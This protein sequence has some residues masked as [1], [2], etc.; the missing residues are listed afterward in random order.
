[1]TTNWGDADFDDEPQTNTVKQVVETRINENGE[2]VKVTKTIKVY[3]R[4]VKVNKRVEERKKRW[5]KFGVCAGV[6]GPEPGMTSQAKEEVYLVLGEEERKKKQRDEEERKEKMKV[7]AMYRDLIAQPRPTSSIPAQPGASG[8]QSGGPALYRPPG[9]G[10]RAA[11]PGA[12]GATPAA[13]QGAEN[14]NL[15]VPPRF[16][17]KGG[18]SAALGDEPSIEETS[19]IHVT[20]LEEDVTE[21]DLRDKFSEFG[22]INR[23][24]VVKDKE[25]GLSKGSAFITF[26]SRGAAKDA[27]DKL[28]GTGWMNLIMNIEWARPSGPRM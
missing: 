27:M 22:A 2:K 26:F 8:A 13:K 16:R 6:E 11:A 15:Y 10:G 12:A 24:Y 25:T 7:E 4:Q 1:M 9:L 14:P 19:R 17:G 3:K 18:A 28:N 20:N 23:V 5:K 21:Q